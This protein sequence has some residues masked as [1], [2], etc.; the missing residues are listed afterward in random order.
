MEAKSILEI[1][2][3]EAKGLERERILKLAI[4]NN[5]LCPEDEVIKNGCVACKAFWEALKEGDK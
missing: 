1:A 4:D 2:V 3:A 5:V